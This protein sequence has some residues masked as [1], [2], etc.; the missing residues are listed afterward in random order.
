MVQYGKRSR[1][2]LRAWLYGEALFGSG[3]LSILGIQRGWRPNAF[4]SAL[5]RVLVNFPTP[6]TDPS[7]LPCR[8]GN[9][10]NL[11]TRLASP[12]TATAEALRAVERLGSGAR[13]GSHAL[14][15]SSPIHWLQVQ[16]GALHISAAAA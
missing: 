7:I 11:N 6:E 5:Q 16:P 14:R 10:S 9:P 3:F 1:G 13:G 15:P 2:N 8:K 4:P 12:D